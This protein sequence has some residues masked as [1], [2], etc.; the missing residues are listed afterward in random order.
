MAGPED[1]AALEAFLAAHADASM[2]PRSNLLAW[3]TSGEGAPHAMRFHLAEQAGAIRGVAGLS[4]AGY[5]ALQVPDPAAWPALAPA[6]RGP[7]AGLS[8]LAPQV[9][10]A[11]DGVR[12]PRTLDA[13]ET[14]YGLD[15][16]G[17]HVPEGPGRLMPLGPEH[18]VTAARWRAAY[19]VETLGTPEAEAS[20][21]AE[22]DVASILR[23]GRHRLLVEGAGPLAM[24]GFNAALPDMVQVGGVYVPPERR[25]RGLARRA[26]ALHL[27][28]AREA[29]A[30]RAVLFTASEPASRAYRGIGFAPLAPWRF[31]RLGAP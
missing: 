4:Q 26:V 20:V 17:L 10:R 25:S 7:L 8:G 31:V 29:G 16:C 3:G 11:L 30:V 21:A 19:H 2:F 14:L 9:E 5:V 6:L 22:A 27:A 23:A 15:L 13:R 12:A 24:T 1:E 28:E 18:A